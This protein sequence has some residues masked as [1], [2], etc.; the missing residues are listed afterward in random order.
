MRSASASNSPGVTATSC[1]QATNPNVPTPPKRQPLLGQIYGLSPLPTQQ[2][3]TL[4]D[5]SG[6]PF[7]GGNITFSRT[8]LFTGQAVGGARVGAGSR[9]SSGASPSRSQ[10]GT[11]DGFV[12]SHC[13]RAR[14]AGARMCGAIGRQRWG[15]LKHAQIAHWTIGGNPCPAS[16]WGFPLFRSDWD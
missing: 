3:V 13:D 2:P 12:A 8:D 9:P 16:N 1:T 10:I 15:V 4:S 6:R 7:P 5:F 14:R 11:G